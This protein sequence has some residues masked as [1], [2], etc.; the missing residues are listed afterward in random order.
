MCRHSLSFKPIKISV[1]IFVGDKL[2]EATLSYFDK[3]NELQTTIILDLTKAKKTI[4][5]AVPGA[6]TPTCSQKHPLGFV[7]RATKLKQKGVDTIACDTVNDAFVMKAWEKDLN[8]GDEVLLLS[9]GKGDFTKAIGCELDLRDLSGDGG[10][11]ES[12]VGGEMRRMA[13][14]NIEH[15]KLGDINK[16]LE[17][18][19]YRRWIAKNIPTPM[20]IGY[21]C[22][23]LDRHGNVIQDNMN[24]SDIEHFSQILEIGSAYRICDFT[25]GATSPCQQTLKN[26]TSLKFLDYK[27]SQ[28]DNYI[29]YVRLVEKYALIVLT[30]NIRDLQLSASSATLYYFNQDIPEVE[31]S[32]MSIRFSCE[33]TI[34]NVN[35]MRDW[36]YISCTECTRKVKENGG[37]WEC[38]DHGPQPEPTYSFKDFISDETGIPNPQQ[39]SPEVLAIEGRKHMFRFHFNTS[40]RIGAVDFTLDDVLDKSIGTPLSIES[41]KLKDAVKAMV[42]CETRT[43]CIELQFEGVDA[44]DCPAFDVQPL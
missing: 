15:L 10:G 44:T 20:P 36:Y 28:S 1:P 13:E 27:I 39:I 21:C 42:K 22:I 26:K 38:V 11:G 34:T 18:M 9:D 32:R 6:F 5:F 43:M 14:N 24:V 17:V 31:R 29:R 4:L 33:A 12:C 23:L 16:I 40:S 35:R 41:E 30:V 7:E 3:N 25:Y 8:V 37:V 2:P 19:V